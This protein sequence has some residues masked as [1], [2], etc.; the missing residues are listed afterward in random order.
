MKKEINIAFFE[1][2]NK[3][4]N[5]MLLEELIENAQKN[6]LYFVN[7]NITE[8]SVLYI[9]SEY[10]MTEKEYNLLYDIYNNNN[11]LKFI[12]DNKLEGKDVK[13]NIIDLM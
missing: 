1:D 2:N 5:V 13:Y 4:I 9:F 12:I 6:N 3:I 8:C 11:G 10:E 7:L